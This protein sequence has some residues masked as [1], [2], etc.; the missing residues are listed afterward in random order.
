MCTDRVSL[1]IGLVACYVN[2]DTP[3]TCNFHKVI[4]SK[5]R[6]NSSEM[7]D[8]LEDRTKITLEK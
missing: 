7:T 2:F 6:F 5:A 1:R 3:C 4:G 8:S